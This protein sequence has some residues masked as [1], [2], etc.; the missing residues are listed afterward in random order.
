M[1]DTDYQNLLEFMPSNGVLIPANQAAID[2]MAIVRQG[3]IQTLKNISR[4]DIKFHRAYFSLINYIYC[5]MPL[6]FRTAISQ[7]NFYTFLKKLKGE[8]D[9]LY[10]FQD[11][12]QF[13]EY[14]SIS[15]G[16]MNQETFKRYVAEQLPVIYE[17]LI[18]KMYPED[19]ANMIIDGI[20]E[21]YKKFLSKL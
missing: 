15:F 11:G 7:S 20:E 9:V 21:E 19:Q 10:E 6:K 12:F 14:Q 1:L 3:E 5:M 8:Y 18:R 17:L 13:V 2:M 16:K 4:R